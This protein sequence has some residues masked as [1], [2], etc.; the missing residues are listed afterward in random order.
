MPWLT[1]NVLD[2]SL[3]EEFLELSSEEQADVLEDGI[4]TR[5]LRSG[6]AI[7]EQVLA[8]ARGEGKQGG[9]TTKNFFICTLMP[10]NIL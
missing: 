1:H 9:S 6:V 7:I 3:L 2:V 10:L 8:R 4:S 5:V